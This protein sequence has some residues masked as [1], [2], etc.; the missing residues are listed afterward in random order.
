MDV[1]WFVR[2]RKVEMFS[3][4]SSVSEAE[5]RGCRVSEA[6]VSVSVSNTK[7]KALGRG[8]VEF[9]QTHPRSSTR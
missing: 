6:A 2:A 1:L 5:M 9:R 3:E 7:S 4:G 8:F